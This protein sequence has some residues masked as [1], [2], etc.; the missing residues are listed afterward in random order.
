MA[1]KSR[2]AE[3]QARVA[4]RDAHIRE[5]WIR[6]MEARIVRDQVQECYRIEGVNHYESCRDLSDKYITLLRENRVKGYKQVDA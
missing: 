4:T 3:L 1:D 6:A 5:S 2:I